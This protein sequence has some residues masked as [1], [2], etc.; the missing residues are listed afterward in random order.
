[1]PKIE[2]VV[3]E[4]TVK[5]EEDVMIPSTS[6]NNPSP[7]PVEL[8]QHETEDVAN[9]AKSR[10]CI[11]PEIH[12]SGANGHRVRPKILLRLECRRCKAA[13]KPSSVAECDIVDH[14]LRR[15]FDFKKGAC[16]VCSQNMTFS[17]LKEHYRDVHQQLPLSMAQTHTDQLHKLLLRC[18][19]PN[20][21]LRLPEFVEQFH[22][23]LNAYEISPSR[24]SNGNRAQVSLSVGGTQAAKISTVPPVHK[25]L[26]R[27]R[28]KAKINES[29]EM[30][31]DGKQLIYSGVAEEDD[32]SKI[33][34]IDLPLIENAN[35]SQPNATLSQ[36]TS[37]PS[38]LCCDEFLGVDEQHSLQSTSAIAVVKSEADGGENDFIHIVTDDAFDTKETPLGR[39]V[40]A[41]ELK[42]EEMEE[43]RSMMEEELQ[44]KNSSHF[45]APL[46]S[47]SVYTEVSKRSS[48]HLA[49]ASGLPAERLMESLETEILINDNQTLL[50]EKLDYSASTSCWP[51][52][53]AVGKRKRPVRSSVQR[54]PIVFKCTQCNKRV[55]NRVS[56]LLGHVLLDHFPDEKP[57]FGCRRCSFVSKRS[58][59]Y[60]RMHVLS[61]HPIT[62]SGFKTVDDAASLQP[63][64]EECI[65]QCFPNFVTVFLEKDFNMLL[66]LVI[67]MLKELK[68]CKL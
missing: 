64:F 32:K 33:A 13:G 59:Y 23:M 7:L 60:I 30:E 36:D 35:S 29:L 27:S 56:L 58:Y 10:R 31:K 20:F 42:M 66:S 9:R 65:V 41:K 67:D 46:L 16:R 4:D 55:D 44:A 1:M 47:R 40:E 52:T 50:D 39:L 62:G 6:R 26:L 17:S 5:E 12:I 25:R 38:P 14:I 63:E 18:F 22:M 53:I 15:H 48:P 68:D 19:S 61:S 24:L 49:V 3:K 2:R 11:T 21:A 54:I 28:A 43:Q 34:P 37:M 57:L 51:P 8:E 45:S